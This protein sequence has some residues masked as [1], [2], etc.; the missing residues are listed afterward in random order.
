MQISRLFLRLICVFVLACTSIAPS[1]AQNS[2]KVKDLKS[3]Q[4]RL[5]KNLKK[6]QQ[7]LTKTGKEKSASKTLSTTWI[8]WSAV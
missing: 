5:Q 4:S 6:S 7:D 2:K 8:A 1:Y 3:Q